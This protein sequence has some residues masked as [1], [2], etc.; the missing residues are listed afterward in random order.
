MS[1]WFDQTLSLPAPTVVA[2]VSGV[3]AEPPP[4]LLSFLG[5]DLVRGIEDLEF[6]DRGLSQF[7][8]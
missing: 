8:G 7:E 3:Q 1:T 5:G 4:A 6:V 2:A